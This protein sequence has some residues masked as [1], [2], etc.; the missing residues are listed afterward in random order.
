MATETELSREI[1]TPGLCIDNQMHCLKLPD[2]RL[3]EKR[4]IEFCAD[5]SRVSGFLPKGLFL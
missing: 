3:V 1:G 5:P 4:G 2:P